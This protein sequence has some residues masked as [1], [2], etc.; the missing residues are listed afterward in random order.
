VALEF[1]DEAGLEQGTAVSGRPLTCTLTLTSRRRIEHAVVELNLRSAVGTAL[2][3]LNSGRDEAGISLQAGENRIE[4][5]LD[6]LPL[7]GG[8]YFWGVRVWDVDRLASELDSSRSF[9]LTVDDGG[10]SSGAAYCG[11][12]WRCESAGHDVTAPAADEP[13]EACALQTG[14]RA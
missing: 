11:R 3:S 12:T 6:S 5:H 9:P 10:R 1:T 13:S 4:L 2:M 7:S 8:V 14:G